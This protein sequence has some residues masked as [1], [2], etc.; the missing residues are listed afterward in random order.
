MATTPSERDRLRVILMSGLSDIK[1]WKRFHEAG[2]DVLWYAAPPPASANFLSQNYGPRWHAGV[3]SGPDGDLICVKECA[4]K[5]EAERWLSPSGW[6]P[7][8]AV[9]LALAKLDGW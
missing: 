4:T 7:E 2:W 5:D 1:L 8:E 6:T 9:A 3:R